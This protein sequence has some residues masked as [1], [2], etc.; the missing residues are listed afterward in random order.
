LDS[1]KKIL[2]ISAINNIKID[3]QDREEFSKVQKEFEI[4]DKCGI[5][6]SESGNIEDVNYE[7]YINLNS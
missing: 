3:D 4:H 5:M 2:D 1:L 7:T 6:I